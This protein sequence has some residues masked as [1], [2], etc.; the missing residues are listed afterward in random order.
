M[1]PTNDSA[2]PDTS[3]EDGAPEDGSEA[4]RRAL[5]RGGPSAEE[6]TRLRNQLLSLHSN[7]LRSNRDLASE[8]LKGSGQVF[9]VDPQMRIPEE[10]LYIRAEDT[11]VVTEDGIENFTAAAPLELD[12]VEAMMKEDSLLERFPPLSREESSAS[13]KR[14]VAAATA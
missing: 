4:P 12:E 8:A 14:A 2:S 5:P 13:A 3:P 6:K 9:S 11:I 10:K 7:L 1:A